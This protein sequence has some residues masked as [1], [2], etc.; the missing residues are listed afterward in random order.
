MV[1]VT[2]TIPDEQVSRVQAALLARFPH[3]TA[4]QAMIEILIRIVRGHEKT[5]AQKAIIVQDDVT[6]S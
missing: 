3:L 5:E 1:N 4:K 2:I 6:L